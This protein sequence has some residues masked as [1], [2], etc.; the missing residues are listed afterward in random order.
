MQRR[1]LWAFRLVT[2]LAGPVIVLG[3]V[4]AGLRLAG[5]GHPAAFTVACTSRGRPAFCDNYRFTEPFFPPGASRAPPAIAFP[6]AKEP[7]TYRIFV[8]GESAALGDPDPAWGF[9]RYLEVLLRDQYPGVRFEVVDA[10]T[11]AVNSHVLLPIARDL[12]RHQPDLFVV[13]AGNNEVVGP[14][15]AAA[16]PRWLIRTRI[17]VA[18]T[19]LGQLLARVLQ[20][21]A[22]GEWRGM[23]T[24][25]GGEVPEGSPALARVYGNFSQNLR[26][27]IAAA[28]AAGAGVVVST[29]PVN[30]RDSAPF[31]SRHR[32]DLSAA[33]ASRW[34]A[35]VEEG[36]ALE[37]RG[38]LAA[39]IGR[40]R[41]AEAIDAAHAE[42]QF[43]LARCLERAG[44]AAPAGEHFV[45]ARDLD[46]LRFRADSRINAIVREEALSAGPGVALVD[47]ESAFL[48]RGVPGA[49]L[50]WEH[51]HLT[52][53]GNDLLARTILPA[54]EKFI[55]QRPRGGGLPSPGECDARLA[56]TR[57]DA[58]RMARDVY[59]RLGNAPF[60]NRLDHA[61][62]LAA[63]RRAGDE[64][65]DS[66][67]DT[68]AQYRR[69]IAG[70]PDDAL[71]RIG[72]GA[73]LAHDDPAT[74]VD[75]LRRGL[76]ALPTHPGARELLAGALGK[77][78]RY[79]EGIAEASALRA[80]R[81]D[82]PPAYLDLG[83]L[84]AEKGDFDA[85]VDAYRRAAELAPS[86]APG[87]WEEIGRIRAHQG[88]KDEAAAA[89]RRAAEPQQR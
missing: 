30:L 17:A 34:D 8:L 25:L 48:A 21:K 16:P 61:G 64:A 15:G 13:Y 84:L 7:G 12:A 62:Q 69:A 75:E 50:F 24:F 58:R 38:S 42:L 46:A 14:F 63:M 89:F 67:A 19:R 40:Y 43:R 47:A 81:P 77:L 60:T 27:I 31:A 73:L 70:M 44:D 2:A 29:V 68:D 11:T 33:D 9:S 79:D 4:E 82:F 74:A 53:R 39:A 37:A 49:D 41:A 10:A 65:V 28:R 80:A 45:R 76:D 5:A 36:A 55:P 56:L 57:W 78:R 20:R 26:G 32:A 86:L 23:E 83:Y 3:A 52:P 72:R 6:A 54:V 18:S 85:S 51:V 59:R 1:R 87:V 71:L 35:L 66:P 22:Q 88:R